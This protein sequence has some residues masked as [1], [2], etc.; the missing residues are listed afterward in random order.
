MITASE[1]ESCAEKLRVYDVVQG[2]WEQEPNGFGANAGHV[3]T[4]LTK[5]L[6]NRNFSDSGIVRTALAPDSLQ[7]AL[8]LSR[9]VDNPVI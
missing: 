6:T 3:L 2:G 7:Y 1:L 9:W 8:R 5:D 4:H